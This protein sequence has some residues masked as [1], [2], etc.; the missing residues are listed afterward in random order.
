MPTDERSLYRETNPGDVDSEKNTPNETQVE[1]SKSLDKSPDDGLKAWSVV[2]GSFCVL[3][4]TFGWINSKAQRLI[5]LLILDTK[6]NMNILYF[7]RRHL[8][9]LL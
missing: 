2:L 5:I 9:K 7:R 3:F 4:C 6:S 8:S 1:P